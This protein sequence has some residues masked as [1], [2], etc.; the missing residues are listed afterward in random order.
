MIAITGNGQDL[1]AL[2][3]GP[4]GVGSPGDPTGVVR[5]VRSTDGGSSWKT[6]GRLPLQHPRQTAGAVGSLVFASATRG[7]AT[8][9]AVSSCAMAG[10]GTDAVLQTTDAGQTWTPV[11]AGQP[12]CDVA[13]V[14]RGG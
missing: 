9:R 6:A 5:V 10:C 7:W 3:A 4:G 2:E 13:R 8:V 14:G 12:R 11:T 1:W